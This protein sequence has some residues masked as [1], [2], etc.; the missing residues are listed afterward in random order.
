M[1]TN[2]TPFRQ[3]VGLCLDPAR[4]LLRGAAFDLP[5]QPRAAEQV[6]ETD[7]PPV[8]GHLPVLATVG[9]G[10]Q[11]ELRLAPPGLIDA[12]PFDR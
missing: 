3:G 4:R 10:D 1:A 12:K 2:R 6:D 5:K 9:T 7:M 8:R 11:A